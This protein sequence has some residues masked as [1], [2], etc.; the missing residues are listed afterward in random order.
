MAFIQL[1]PYRFVGLFGNSIKKYIPTTLIRIQC[2]FP[3]IKRKTGSRFWA[4]T[5]TDLFLNI[6]IAF[7]K[8]ALLSILKVNSPKSVL[9]TCHFTLKILETVPTFLFNGKLV[10]SKENSAKELNDKLHKRIIKY[11]ILILT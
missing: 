10:R 3:N 6:L 11:L 5:L 2:A 8:G 7:N 9:F 4:I 1:N